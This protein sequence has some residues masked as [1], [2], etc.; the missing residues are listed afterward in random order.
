[1]K[2]VICILLLS[3]LHACNFTDETRDLSGGWE[4]V[5]EG[6]AYKVLDGGS[7]FIPWEV[8][9]YGDNNDFII[10]AQKPIEDCFLGEGIRS[11]INME[12]TRRIIGSS[13]TR[14]NYSWAQ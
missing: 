4:F 7:V 1:M 14:K 12:R 10:A 11:R 9:E 8:I 3:L 5:D 13:G 2:K 6:H